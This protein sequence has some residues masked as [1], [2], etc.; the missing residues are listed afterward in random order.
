TKANGLPQNGISDTLIRRAGDTTKFVRA[1]AKPAQNGTALLEV[2]DGRR[3]MHKLF[4][5]SKLISA[6]DFETFWP[7]PGPGVPGGVVEPFI[8]LLADKGLVP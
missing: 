1:P 8:Q 2:E 7:K 5:D 3:P 6:A 4:V